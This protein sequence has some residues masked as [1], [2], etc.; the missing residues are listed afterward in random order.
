[1]TKAERIEQKNQEMFNRWNKQLNTVIG[2]IAWLTRHRDIY[3]EICNIMSCTKKIRKSNEFYEYIVSTYADSVLMNVRR[4]VDKDKKAVSLKNLL[5]AI[6]KHPDVLSRSRFAKQSQPEPSEVEAHIKELEKKAKVCKNYADKF[7]AH[8]D[9]KN[10]TTPTPE[11]R[12]L[13]SYI[14]FV[15]S[16]IQRYYPIFRGEGYQFKPLSDDWKEIFYYAWLP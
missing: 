6:H 8:C 3:R 5:V 11:N 13:D 14:D 16:L 7:I 9:K 12:H 2:E 15:Q 1:M 4:Q 10:A